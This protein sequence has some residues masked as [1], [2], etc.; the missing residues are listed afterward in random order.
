[1]KKKHK[2]QII[3]AISVVVLS[4]CCLPFEIPYTINSV[5]KILPAR[6][7]ILSRGSDGD[8]LTYTVNHAN[9]I[10]KTYQLTSFD[11]GE[12]IVLDLDPALGYGNIVKQGDTIGVIYS[13]GQQESLIQLTGELQV[14]TATLKVSMS[15]N[16]MTE[17]RE[18]QERVA[19]A[20]SEYDKQVKIVERLNKL[21]EKDLIAEADYQMAT[22]QLTIISKAVKVREAELGSSMS[23]EKVEEIN[24]LKEQILA[25]ENK[26]AFLNQQ[27]NSQNSI[28]VP[29]SG[30]IERTFSNDTLLVLSNFDSGIACI[31]VPL[32]DAANIYEGEKVSLYL[33]GDEVI[34]SGSIQMKHPVMNIIDGRQCI[35]VVAKINSVSNDFVSGVFAQAEIDCGNV[36]LQTYLRRNILN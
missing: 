21:L 13:S 27:I 35:V 22:D 24:K 7:W 14:L 2:I 15:G 6:Q 16:K 25:V 34:L 11:R 36:S 29:F 9:G 18:A 23:G 33:T 30:R 1:M 31:P 20:E 17:V 3:I 12:S 10:N 26:I 4:I 28:I 32:E 5:A 19:M 8:F